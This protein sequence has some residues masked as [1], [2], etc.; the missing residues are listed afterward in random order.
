MT[1]AKQIHEILN[2]ALASC[3]KTAEGVTTQVVELTPDSSY[4]SIIES[5]ALQRD[6]NLEKDAIKLLK[7]TIS[8]TNGDKDPLVFD[9]YMVIYHEISLH[10][11]EPQQTAIIGLI[12]DHYMGAFISDGVV[13]GMTKELIIRN[14][15]RSID[16][17]NMDSHL[18]CT[19]R[20]LHQ[21]FTRIT[22][23]VF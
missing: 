21:E 1:E 7:A 6:T 4:G 19:A 22:N 15:I 18:R 3:F 17:Q 13:K 10:T 8:K 5:R 2:D 20:E 16:P 9:Y 11:G 23:L 12:Y 14:T